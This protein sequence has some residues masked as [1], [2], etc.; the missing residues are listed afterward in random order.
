MIEL[1]LL[2]RRIS[3]PPM[4]TDPDEQGIAAN[5]LADNCYDSNLP[6]GCHF[7]VGQSLTGRYMRCALHDM[8]QGA[9]WILQWRSPEEFES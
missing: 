3:S 9:G 5:R 6:T 1:L 8:P 2:A 7:I 4:F